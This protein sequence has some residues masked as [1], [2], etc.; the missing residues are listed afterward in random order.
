MKPLTRLTLLACLSSPALAQ[1]LQPVQM[2]AQLRSDLNA[3]AR[4]YTGRACSGEHMALATPMDGLEP[5]LVFELIYRKLNTEMAAKKAA[6]V[7]QSYT[8]APSRAQGIIYGTERRKAS[9]HTAFVMM[10]MNRDYAYVLGCRL[11]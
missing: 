10:F 9:G 11:S 4:A 3:H 5:T 6:G 1:G 8:L 7:L 2:S